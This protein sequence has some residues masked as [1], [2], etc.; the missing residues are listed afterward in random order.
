MKSGSSSNPELLAV[1]LNL[2]RKLKTQLAGDQN[3]LGKEIQSQI[4]EYIKKRG[5]YILGRREKKFVFQKSFLCGARKELEDFLFEFRT[6]LT[7]LGMEREFMHRCQLCLAELIANAIEHGCRGLPA[8]EFHLK[9]VLRR[10]G[11]VIQISDPGNG[12]D[13]EKNLENARK[14]LPQIQ[15]ADRNDPGNFLS[16]DFFKTDRNNRNLGIALILAV[17]GELSYTNGG[18]DAMVTLQN[19]LSEGVISFDNISV[20][21]HPSKNFSGEIHYHKI[22]S[23][24]FPEI[25]LNGNIDGNSEFALKE[26]SQALERKGIFEFVVNFSRVDYANS[27]GISVLLNSIIKTTESGG[28]IAFFGM[29]HTLRNVFRMVGIFQTVFEANSLD[30]ALKWLSK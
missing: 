24:E 18:R 28:K 1:E 27:I 4:S 12:F 9:G 23:K 3:V 16:R 21:S 14:K 6:R 2:L 20:S 30:E 10:G 8:A 11:G 13:F 29:N 22:A 26:V 25:L 5:A 19:K 7:D 15:T 17:G